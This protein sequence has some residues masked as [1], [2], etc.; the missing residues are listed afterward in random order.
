MPGLKGTL[1][2]DWKRHHHVIPPFFLHLSL[3]S[4]GQV[5]LAVY[6]ALVCRKA[7]SSNTASRTLTMGGSPAIAKASPD[8]EE[9]NTAGSRGVH[10]KV[11]KDIN[12]IALGRE[13][14]G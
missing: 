5:S 14:I 7:A 13:S 11:P 12:A 3:D 1:P 4:S 9:D 10:A 6:L 2:T 8:L